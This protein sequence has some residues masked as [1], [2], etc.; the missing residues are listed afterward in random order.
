MFQHGTVMHRHDTDH[1]VGIADHDGFE[2]LPL[3]DDAPHLIQRVL[4]RAN[5]QRVY[6]VPGHHHE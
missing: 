5:I 6:F 3:F 4:I 2:P 1:I